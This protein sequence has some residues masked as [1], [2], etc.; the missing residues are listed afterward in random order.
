MHSDCQ[1]GLLHESFCPPKGSH[2]PPHIFSLMKPYRTG[3]GLASQ[4]LEGRAGPQKM[5]GR[6]GGHQCHEGIYL[7]SMRWACLSLGAGPFKPGGPSCGLTD[8]WAEIIFGHCEVTLC[9]WQD[10]NIQ[11][12][13]SYLGVSVAF[14][15]TAMHEFLTAVWG[16][17]PSIYRRRTNGERGP[18][19]LR[20]SCAC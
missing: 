8:H 16:S 18:Y 19:H 11:L 2:R 1:A 17:Q 9:V 10:V 4:D 13:D 20:S 5:L 14:V 7:F 3:P 6:L 12:L 15:H